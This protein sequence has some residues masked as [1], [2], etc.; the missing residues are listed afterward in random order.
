MRVVVLGG[1][2]GGLLTTRKLEDRLPDG[3]ELLLVDD[4]GDHL[5]QHELH[6]AIRRPS[7]TDAISIPL[8][9]LTER[10]TVRVADVEAVDREERV[11]ELDGGD[12]IEY[13][14]AV[15]AFGA[16]TAYYGIEGLEEYATP[17]KRLEH[18]AA[19]RRE[20]EA[21]LEAGGGEVVVGGA[22]L[23]GV[24]V[25]GELAQYARDEGVESHVS[26]TLLEQRSDIAPSF[27]ANFR[28]AVRDELRERDVDIRTETTVTAVDD[29]TVSLDDGEHAYDQFVWTGG[30]T[31]NHGLGG[32]RPSVRADLR[33]DDRTFGIGDA[34]EITDAEGTVVPAAALAAVRA[35]E[36]VA[37][38]VT[39]VVEAAREGEPRPRLKQWVFDT[40]GWL[41]SVGDGAVAQ[42]GPE[43]FTGAAANVIKSSVGVTYLAEHGSLRRA[44]SVVQEDLRDL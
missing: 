6:R 14:A 3:V 13:D 4:T 42:L 18:A 16:E 8:T 34:V 39:R 19:V 26:V 31:G 43:V 44:V 35:S 2:Y 7:F 27:P 30:I 41:V 10:A 1:G 15:V 38:N 29:E 37:E 12:S 11:V 17:L 25:A 21:V 9:E 40:P 33:I 36:T 28:D 24:Q 23:S 32:D 5:V 20:F 22:G